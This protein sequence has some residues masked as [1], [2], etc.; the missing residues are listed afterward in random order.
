MRLILLIIKRQN[1][2][3]VVDRWTNTGGRSDFQQSGCKQNCI[4][5]LASLVQRLNANCH[6][7][8][9]ASRTA[10]SGKQQLFSGVCHTAIDRFR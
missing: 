5:V 7:T 3:T 2:T 9:T 1:V 8:E 4:A 10:K 6:A